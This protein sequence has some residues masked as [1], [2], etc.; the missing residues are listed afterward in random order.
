M[1]NTFNLVNDLLRKELPDSFFV[2][3][4]GY[5]LLLSRHKE[6]SNG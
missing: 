5:W 4:L 3:H 6:I 2:G 1:S